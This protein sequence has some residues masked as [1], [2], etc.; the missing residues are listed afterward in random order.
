MTTL[1]LIDDSSKVRILMKG[2]NTTE[3]DVYKANIMAGPALHVNF[4]DTVEVYSTF[5]KQMKAE[6]PQ[7]NVSEVN[8]YKNRQSGNNSSGKR[9]SSGI[10]DGEVAD[11]FYEKHEYHALS[12]EQNNNIRLKR[13]KRGHVGKAQCGGG[14]DGKG[15]GKGSHTVTIKSM[16]RTISELGAKY[17]NFNIPDDD[18]D[19][20]SEDEEG[21]GASNSSN[22]AWTRQIKKKGKRS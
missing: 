19:D 15:G 5:I 16:H 6:N 10:S 3:L 21:A 13:V 8:Y 17:G 2:I 7:M 18:Y 12:S 20:L 14:R 11:R 1:G 9:G 22:Q 4:M